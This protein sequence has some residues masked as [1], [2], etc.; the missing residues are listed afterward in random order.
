MTQKRR[1]KERQNGGERKG[2]ASRR[3]SVCACARSCHFQ[4]GTTLLTS[5]LGQISRDFM[6]ET[7]R[8]Q[9]APRPADGRTCAERADLVETR[10][11]TWFITSL[12]TT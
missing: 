2:S 11:T 3:K 10:S 4:A 9:N 6:P 1:R 7:C 8:K 5:I 12:R